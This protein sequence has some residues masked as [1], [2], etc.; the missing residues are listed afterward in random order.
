MARKSSLV[1]ETTVE[2][3]DSHET[4]TDLIPDACYDNI[5]RQRPAQH[6]LTNVFIELQRLRERVVNCKDSQEDTDLATAAVN[7]YLKEMVPHICKFCKI[8]GG[9]QRSTSSSSRVVVTILLVSSNIISINIVSSTIIS[10]S[11]V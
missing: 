5:S 6:H 2:V 3:L 7:E 9:L 8:P 4:S 10:S 1:F 11:R